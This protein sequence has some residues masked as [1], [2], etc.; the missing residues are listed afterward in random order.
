MGNLNKEVNE[1]C[2]LIP[3][4]NA[5]RTIEKLIDEVKK[6][7]VDIIIVEDGSND[8]TY[9][10][11]KDK[12]VVILKHSR[13]KGKGDALKTGFRYAEKLKYKAVIT[14]DADGQHDPHEIPKFISSFDM[15]GKMQIGSR[16]HQA[17]LIPH[18]RAMAIKVA[19]FFISYAAGQYIVDTQ[20][21]YRL[22]P[23]SLIQQI[24]L[25]TKGYTCETEFLI[26]AGAYDHKFQSIPVKVIYPDK[27]GYFSHFR[28]I[29]DIYQISMYVTLYIFYFEVKKCIDFI[30]NRLNVRKQPRPTRYNFALPLFSTLF[31]LSVFF[32]A[33]CLQPVLFFWQHLKRL[34]PKLFQR[35]I[36][37]FQL[38]EQERLIIA[39]L[40]LP[41]L[42]FLAIL[43]I[44]F[45]MRSLLEDFI[46]KY[47]RFPL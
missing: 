6:Y 30:A 13:R 35:M 5:D 27:N 7:P 24:D 18:N 34:Y 45:P 38:Q 23:I 1:I 21:G 33:I 22:Y 17:N 29:R 20:C 8:R 16:M 12:E 3:A 4:Y 19:N 9:Q 37:R 36:G 15:S 26:K 31:F 32:L 2:V 28:P 10:I 39:Y 25:W 47:Y 40:Q 11:I 46:N 41:R 43:G 42:L 14:L 44:F